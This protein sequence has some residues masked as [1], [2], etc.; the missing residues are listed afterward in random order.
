MRTII[1]APHDPVW[2]EGKSDFVEEI[3]RK[4]CEAHG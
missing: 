4:A 2:P 1:V 3:I